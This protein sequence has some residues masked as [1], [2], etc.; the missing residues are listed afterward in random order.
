MLLLVLMFVWVV[1]CIMIP[2]LACRVLLRNNKELHDRV[3]ELVAKLR[4]DWE[5]FHEEL[6]VMCLFSHACFLQ[7][8]RVC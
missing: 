7:L 4:G 3:D 5:Q 8:M 1:L 6:E 2:S